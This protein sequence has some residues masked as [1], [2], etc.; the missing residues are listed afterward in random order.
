MWVFGHVDSVVVGN[1]I[2]PFRVVVVLLKKNGCVLSCSKL[3]FNNIM[4]C[5]P[6]SSDEDTGLLLLCSSL[7][8]RKEDNLHCCWVESSLQLLLGYCF[9]L[10]G[11]GSCWFIRPLVADCWLLLL[12]SC[13]VIVY[14]E[15][16]IFL[17]VE[18]SQFIFFSI[19]FS[20][21]F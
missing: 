5:A 11:M 12:G 8:L 3:L 14:G 20:H 7:S 9:L 10:T 13:R 17:R 6:L 19:R 15:D 4:I 1:E 2:C 18:I 21:F 16:T